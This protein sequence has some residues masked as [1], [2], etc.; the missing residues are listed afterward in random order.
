MSKTCIDALL[1]ERLLTRCRTEMIRSCMGHVR[2][3]QGDMDGSYHRYSF[4]QHAGKVVP[5][6]TGER[7]LASLTVY[8]RLAVDE[9][10]RDRFE[11]AR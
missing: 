6:A 1:V 9:F 2:R 10:G 3:V 7:S 4:N 8:Y 11:E 5:V